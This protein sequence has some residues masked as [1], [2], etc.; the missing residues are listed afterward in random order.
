MIVSRCGES[1]WKDELAG[2]KIRWGNTRVGSSPTFGTHLD[3]VPGDHGTRVNFSK[4]TPGS[5]TVSF[6]RPLRVLQIL[7]PARGRAT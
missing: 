5:G 6:K 2:L 1:V 7:L 3:N 4:T